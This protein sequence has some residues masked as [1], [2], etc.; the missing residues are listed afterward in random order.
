[1]INDLIRY[2]KALKYFLIVETHFELLEDYSTKLRMTDYSKT[3]TQSIRKQAIA[4]MQPIIN[5]THKDLVNT[6][7]MESSEIFTQILNKILAVGRT[8]SSSHTFLSSREDLL[9]EL[10]MLTNSLLEVVKEKKV[11]LL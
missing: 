5:N 11:N 10:R 6:Y 7:G 4:E 8:L 9:S 2:R 1:M 3:P